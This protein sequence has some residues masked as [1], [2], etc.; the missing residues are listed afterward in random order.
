MVHAEA[1]AKVRT[2][3]RSNAQALIDLAL[4]LFD[5]LF[6]EYDARWAARRDRAT[7]VR[8]W[9]KPRD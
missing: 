7:T 5:I 2:E 4:E 8:D 6:E 9:E 3:L 1:V